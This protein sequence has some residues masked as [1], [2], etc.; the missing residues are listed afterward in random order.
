MQD[1]LRLWFWI[2]EITKRRQQTRYKMM[3]QDARER[4]GA[5]AVKVEGSLE[6]RHTGRACH[7]S[8]FQQK[9]PHKAGD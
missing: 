1:D 2:V 6:I 8:S 7:T 9:M 5:D 4:F 3:E